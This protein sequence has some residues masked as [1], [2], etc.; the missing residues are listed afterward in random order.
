M[1]RNALMRIEMLQRQVMVMTVLLL[2]Q[3]LFTLLSQ[4]DKQNKVLAVS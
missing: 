2:L 4:V 1:L 3:Q